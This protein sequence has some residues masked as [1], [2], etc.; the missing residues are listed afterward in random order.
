MECE[1]IAERIARSGK[2]R[3]GVRFYHHLSTHRELILALRAAV[4]EL[5]ADFKNYI[6]WHKTWPVAKVPE[7]ALHGVEIKLIFA[8]RVVVSEMLADFQI[9][10]VGHES[11]PLANVPEVAHTLSFYP[12]RGC[13]GWVGVKIGLIFVL[14]TAVP[15][16]Q[17]DFQYCHIWA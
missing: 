14:H 12:G 3:H 1:F 4:S 15:D 13:V 5:Q 8:V 2:V 11:W 16:I 10:T 6:C 7:V 9:P 17:T